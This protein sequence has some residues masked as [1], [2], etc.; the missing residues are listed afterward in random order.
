[1]IKKIN[2]N[3]HS[4]FFGFVLDLSELAAWKGLVFNAKYWKLLLGECPGNQ[5]TSSSIWNTLENEQH[6]TLS[7]PKSHLVTLLTVCHTILVILV[8]RV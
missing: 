5:A 1:M 3:D 8:Q 2:I 7:L 4:T 6:I